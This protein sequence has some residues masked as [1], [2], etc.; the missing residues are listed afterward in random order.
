MQGTEDTGTMCTHSDACMRPALD[1]MLD[2]EG[3]AGDTVSVS[4]DEGI[5]DESELDAKQ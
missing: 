4:D 5:E 3:D 2:E 1:D